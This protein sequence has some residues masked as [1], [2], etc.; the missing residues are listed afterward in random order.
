MSGLR[1]L[2]AVF[3]IAG[4][5]LATPVRAALSQ[6]NPGRITPSTATSTC[7]GTAAT[8]LC[9]AE[10]LLACLARND[11]G[12][13]R[14]VGA[15]LPTRSSETSGPQQTEYSIERISVIRE[16]D[17]TDDTRD[18]EWF[19]PGY[20]LVEVSRRSCPASDAGCADGDWDYLQIYLR[21]AVSGAGAGPWQIVTWRS[22]TEGDTTPEIPDSF[23]RPAPEDSAQ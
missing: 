4:L 11:D 16:D 20:T 13:C 19:K 8:P 18:L 14:R 5:V 9:A 10:T 2:Y 15:T 6:D 23:Q 3:L 17:I 22:D 21:P 1:S 7:L 12:L